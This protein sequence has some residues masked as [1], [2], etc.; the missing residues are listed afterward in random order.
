MEKKDYLKEIRNA[1][2]RELLE[3]MYVCLR[4]MEDFVKEE[5]RQRYE[6]EHEELTRQLKDKMARAK[7][8]IEMSMM[9]YGNLNNDYESDR[10]L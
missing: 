5:N 10:I 4:R 9:R 6:L 2:D 3:A 8:E 1:T 7:M